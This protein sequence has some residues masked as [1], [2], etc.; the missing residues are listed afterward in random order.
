VLTSRIQNVYKSYQVFG[1]DTMSLPGVVKTRVLTSRRE[2][3]NSNAAHWYRKK[4]LLAL[5]ELEVGVVLA[6]RVWLGAL[7]SARYGAATS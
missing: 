7:S 6:V 2:F 3:L 1:N 5:K 4:G